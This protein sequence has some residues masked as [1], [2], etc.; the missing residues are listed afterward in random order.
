[1]SE[2]D[3][4][5]LV[6]G[7]GP[8]GLT[9]AA[10]LC[11][12]GVDCRVVDRLT[13]RMPY[14]KAVGVQPR[15]LEVWAAMG[16]LR[17]AL[18]AAVPMFG[19]LMYVNGEQAARLELTLPPD[20]PYGF[21]ALPQY[22]TERVLAEHLAGLGTR[23]ER[24]TELLSFEQDPERVTA[25]LRN[26]S[27][28]EREVTARYLVGCDG[29][30]SVVRKG[31]ELS[32]EGD[33][34]PEEY[35]LGDVEVDWDMPRGYGVRSL[36]QTDDGSTDDLLVCIPLPGRNRYRMSM[37][38]PPELSA[39]GTGAGGTADDGVTHGLEAGRAPELH[40]IQAVLDRLSPQR[41]TAS[42]LR[43][44]S[45]FRISHRIVDRYADGRV[46]VAGDAAHI[47][48]PT[49]AQG[50]NTGIQDA[51]NLA[52]KLALAVG[53]EASEGLV[54][55][56]DA[57][58]RP[59]GEEVVGR[60]VR[61]ARAGFEADP[62]DVSTIIRREAQLLVG[63][64]DSPIVSPDGGSSPAPGERVPDCGGLERDVMTF[65][66]RLF[67]VLDG[68]RHTVLLYADADAQTPEL[69]ACATA[70]R[71]AAHG[72][73]DVYAVLAPG[74]RWTAREV[75][76]PTLR[77]AAGSFR[78]AYGAFGGEAFVVRPDGYLGLRGAAAQAARVSDHLRLTFA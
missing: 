22:E 51:Y 27:G 58:R 48:P 46:M 13:E 9:A 36:H 11:R 66:L 42:A 8:V 64:P 6:V 63:Y 16:V 69:A 2:T 39:A 23:V 26:A 38:V 43:W 31:L 65:P 59:V 77:D 41:T 71:E 52:W 7:A 70:A 73:V 72:K 30:H 35:M 45:V 60:T 47:H 32:F 17:A 68:A 19:Q 44:S 49:G 40:H 50:M 28:T 62:N 25:R 20:I 75:P 61:H 12:R 24:G 21:A 54:A 10:E 1:M 18:D 4:D 78:E 34:F 3:V 29:A 67:D 74:T 55:S 15:T 14:A 37:L 57:E 33:A 56:Y 76:P 53:G 5:V